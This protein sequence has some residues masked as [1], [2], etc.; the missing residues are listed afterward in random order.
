MTAGSL[1]DRWFGLRA[2]GS[3][4]P[5]ELVAG[6]TTF[7]AMS[8]ILA[9]NP[10]ILAE[11]G[12]DRGAV[13]SATAIASALMTAVF[14]L[15]T[16]YPIALAPGMG[17]NAF[18]TYTICLQHRVPW[19]AALGLVFTGGLLFLLLSVTGARRRILEAIP[20]ELKTAISCGIG[21]FIAFIG[22]Q[23]AGLVADHPVTL[24]TAGRLG[25]APALV[26]L[27]GLIL[28]AALAWRRVRGAILLSIAAVTVAGLFLSG[29]DGRPL[30]PRPDFGAGWR[31]V[32]WPA[33]L[34]PT[35]LHLDLAYVT[36]HFLELA[37]LLLALL[38]V[39]L[40]DNMGTLIGVSRRAGLLD[41]QGRL[42]RLGRALAA[43]ATAAMVGSTLGTSTVTSY[44]ES[45]AGVEEGGRT[46][47]TAL[48]VAA[49]FLLSLFLH[50][51]ILLVPT[52]ATAPALI[53]VGVFMMQGAAEIDW[54]QLP[55]ALPAALTILLMPLT[56]S[57]SEGLA[58]GF[59]AW[60]ALALVTGRARTLSVTAWVLA[61]LFLAHVVTR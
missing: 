43:D 5:R 8:Y 11:S 44:I 24:V 37:P 39:D 22:F 12:M 38:F 10:A 25:S 6:L 47:L 61:L 45:A 28:A 41:A 35:F 59:L 13:I 36:T 7:A 32:D 21:L 55:V 9:V 19:P 51:L 33:S 30:T 3:T 23:K 31:P 40:F 42:P 2:A 49:G 15:A 4:V 54:R 48:T 57:I 34:A 60:F 58:L 14:A 18:F 27:A 56:F 16:N 50:P 20:P 53:L 52:V 17:M 46:G 29:P 1:V 26:S